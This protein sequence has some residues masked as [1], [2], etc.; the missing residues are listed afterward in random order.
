MAP[1]VTDI[2]CPYFV[3]LPFMTCLGDSLGGGSVRCGPN[4]DHF[5]AALNVPTWT[6]LS[7]GPSERRR[8]R[9]PFMQEQMEF[10]FCIRNLPTRNGV[11]RGLAAGLHCFH[12][13]VN[14]T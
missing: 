6:V 1:V 11:S 5:Y 4:L 2:A 9:T 13:L 3:R 14:I 7:A 12:S 10:N 8:G